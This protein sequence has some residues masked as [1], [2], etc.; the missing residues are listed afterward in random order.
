MPSYN[1]EKYISEAIESVL[2][3]SFKDFELIILDDCSKDN[4]QRII[5]TYQRRDPRIRAL[6]HKK[7]MGIA[8]TLNDLLAEAKGTYVA[9]TASDD[10]WEKSKL[11]KQLAILQKDDSLIVWSEGKLIDSDGVLTGETFTQNQLALHKK[12]SGNLFEA[13][14]ERNFIFGSTVILKRSSVEGIQFC[15]KLKYYNDCKFFVDLSRHHLFFFIPEPLASYR[16][17]GKGA[18]VSDEKGWQSDEIAFV[19]LILE[20]YGNYISNRTKANWLLLVGIAYSY[21]G[22]KASARSII[23]KAI[24]LNPLGKK[25]FGFLI[26]ALTNGDDCIA[27]FFVAFRSYYYRMLSSARTR[28][29]FSFY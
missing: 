10:V 2:N 16:V 21:F 18:H 11:E 15:E 25:N 19:R 12:K 5:E 8:K 22:E 17:H 3:Q 23:F 4:S 24:G 6:F 28:G 27:K 29:V 13:L 26:F 14:V 9:F 7:N 1:H 20:E